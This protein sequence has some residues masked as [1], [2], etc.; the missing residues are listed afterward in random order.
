MLSELDDIKEFIEQ[1][2]GAD[3]VYENSDFIVVENTNIDKKIKITT[4]QL[5]DFK[6]LEN[7]NKKL[8][9]FKDRGFKFGDYIEVFITIVY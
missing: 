8:K 6:S 3:V 9:I 1:L 2:S 4:N 5:I 7:E